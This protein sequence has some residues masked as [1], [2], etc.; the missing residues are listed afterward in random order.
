MK[1][2]HLAMKSID[3]LPFDKNFLSMGAEF[4]FIEEIAF[5][6]MSLLYRA[7]SIYLLN[8]INY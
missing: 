2:K 8:K 7:Q 5:R 4:R 3:I 1:R 6:P